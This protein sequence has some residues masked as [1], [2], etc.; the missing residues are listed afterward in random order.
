MAND[1]PFATLNHAASD[2]RIPRESN[3]QRFG[4]TRCF[5][6]FGI[7]GD[8]PFPTTHASLRAEVEQIESNL[9]AVLA[10]VRSPSDRAGSGRFLG[11]V[12]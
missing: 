9:M 1:P 5:S 12:Q 11:V 8:A 4:I 10:A 3:N 7:H 2:S 6:Q